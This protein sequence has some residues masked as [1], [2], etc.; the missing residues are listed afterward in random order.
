MNNPHSSESFVYI[1]FWFLSPTI[2]IGK[3]L[4]LSQA[5]YLLFQLCNELSYKTLIS[6]FNRKPAPIY[7]MLRTY[8]ISDL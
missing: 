7:G 8:Y 2:R 6:M 3:T 1:F 5:F 4:N